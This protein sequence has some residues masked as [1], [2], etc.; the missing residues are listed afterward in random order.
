MEVT[1]TKDRVDFNLT[2]FSVSS[3]YAAGMKED[4]TMNKHKHLSFEERFTIKTLL[5]V[6]ASF[7]EIGRALGRDCT[8]IS[9]EVR[10]HLLFQKI[11]CFGRPFNDC[12][13]AAAAP[14]PSS[15][16]VRT[17][18]LKS[19]AFVLGAIFIVR[20]ISRNSVPIYPGLPMSAMAVL[21]E[22]AV[23]SKNISTPLALPRRSM[24]PS[25]LKPVAASAFLKPKFFSLTP[26]S[27]P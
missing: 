8:T 7:K 3:C 1:L 18:V 12:A 11:G 22:K 23:L 9:K 27:R 17:A 16:P 14:S 24:K 21:K 6:S 19:A 20:I 5:D 2:F 10:N 25:A 13:N 4:T 15:V 26:L